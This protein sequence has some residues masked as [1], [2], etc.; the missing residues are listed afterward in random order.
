MLRIGLVDDDGEFLILMKGL[1]EKYFEE[2]KLPAC[3]EIF[4][5]PEL[6]Y[7]EFK[8]GMEYDI[9]FLDIEMPQMDGCEL[10][11]RIRERSNA[12]KLIF[13]T[14][15]SEFMKVG[16]KLEIFDF[17]MKHEVEDELPDLM[18][19]LLLKI[20]KDELRFYTIGTH[21]RYE[22]IA[23]HDIIY[24]YKRDQNIRFVLE[25]KEIQE[26]KP[27]KKFLAELNDESFVLVERGYIVNLAHVVRLNARELCLSNGKTVTVSKEHMQDVRNKLGMYCMHTI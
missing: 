2:K 11:G 26:R 13:L 9:C 16:Y 19:R 10:A 24:I 6:L 7:L 1:L 8:E 5:R 3:I 12:V 14:A 17:I 22:R 21:S 25:D 18:E 27:L 23:Y 15:H 20:K 4:Q